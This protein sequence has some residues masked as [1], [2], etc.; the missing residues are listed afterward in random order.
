MKTLSANQFF[1]LA[2][3][4]LL[5]LPATTTIAQ[6]NVQAFTGARIIDGT[7]AAP[8]ENGVL[9]IQGG[10]ILAVGP[11][12]STPIPAQAQRIALDGM[13]LI[14]GMINAHGH[15][16]DDTEHKL[17]LYSR[18]GVTTVL[19]L[20]GEDQR[21]VPLRDASLVA[22]PGRAR[23]FIA[24]PIPAPATVAAG[25]SAVA[26]LA[27]MQV[28]WVK[29]RVER[30]NMPEAVYGAI[31]AASHAAGLPIAAHMYDLATTKGLLARGVDMLAHSVRDQAMDEETFAMMRARD[32]CL[33][34]TLMREVSTYVYDQTPDFYSDPFFLAHADP[35][36]MQALIAPAAQ[37]RAAS[38]RQR[39]EA[40]LAMA[41]HNLNLTH[42]A[43]I[44]IAMGTDSGA[45]S[46]RFPGYFEHLELELMVDAGMSEAAV[47]HA[48]TGMAADCA[49]LDE[50]LGSL[51]PGKLADFIVLE[52]N[53][54][55]D[56]RNTRRIRSIWIGG[57][58][59]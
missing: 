44:R 15:A 21:H 38:A 5:L 53:P 25:E 6:E 9:L 11:Q 26:E 18:Y 51:Q 23:L 7:G 28:D 20:G 40:D 13:T 1:R 24:G 2:L 58:E 52:A 33:S 22:T 36:E 39:G 46:G 59:I 3:L 57:E 14:P 43:G 49:N 41:Q 54:L 4:A 32:V 47:I 12:A 8:L 17:K 31:V 45:F 56:I 16:A 37:Q 27:A 42:Q 10:R 19:S 50:E 34:P 55:D 30:G 48:A 29:I 35:A